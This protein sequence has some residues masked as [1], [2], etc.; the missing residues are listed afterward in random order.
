[1]HGWR[2]WEG[3]PYWAWK[4][5]MEQYTP[6]SGTEMNKTTHVILYRIFDLQFTLYCFIKLILLCYN[7][8][9]KNGSFSIFHPTKIR[10][11]FNFLKITFLFLIVSVFLNFIIST[12]QNLLWPEFNFWVLF[13]WPLQSAKS[14]QK[15]MGQ[16]MTL[17]ENKS[18]ST[19]HLH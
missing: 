9:C 11:F 15:S 1:M 4:A 16:L 19:G 13:Y 17:L 12:V 5:L 7:W 6:L 14:I 10:T 8:T 18:K 3:F 2:F